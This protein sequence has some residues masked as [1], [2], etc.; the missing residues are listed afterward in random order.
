M[1]VSASRP[2]NG[3]IYADTH[4]K[5]DGK[6]LGNKSQKETDLK[7]ILF[8]LMQIKDLRDIQKSNESR[9]FYI[10]K[11]TLKKFEH[12][13]N[14]KEISKYVN[15][16]I[17]NKTLKQHN[18]W[19][20]IV[21]E[22]RKY[23]IVESNNNSEKDTH[24]IPLD[25]IY[26]KSNNI[27]YPT[28]F[29]LVEYQFLEEFN[30]FSRQNTSDII[31]EKK[32]GYIVL[33][34]SK[35]GQNEIINTT[36]I[37]LNDFTKRDDDIYLGICLEEFDF[38]VDY[39]FI[40]NQN[41]NVE[42]FLNIA[43]E[44]IEKTKNEV[45]EKNLK[46]K[47]SEGIH[48][49][50]YPENIG[51]N[52]YINNEQIYNKIL[53]YFS[54]DKMYNQFI[55]SFNNIK[56]HMLKENEID[57]NRIEQL[58]LEEKLTLDENLVYLFDESKLKNNILDDIFYYYQYNLCRP[59]NVNDK[60]ILIEN[61]FDKEDERKN[62]DDK[63][64][65]E[66]LFKF[67]SYNDICCNINRKISLISPEIYQRIQ[68]FLN[69]TNTNYTKIET[70]LIKINNEL[71]IYFNKEKNFAKLTNTVINKEKSLHE[72]NIW[73]IKL[74]C[75]DNKN[76]KEIIKEKIINVPNISQSIIK[77]IFLISQQKVEI[78]NIM[79]DHTITEMENFVLINRQW[80][81]KYK[82]H[83]KYL[84]ILNNLT[85]IKLESNNYYEFKQYLE[86][87]DTKKFDN[88]NQEIEAFPDELKNPQYILFKTEKYVLFEFPK[89]FDIINIDLFQQLIKEESENDS[90]DIRINIK[91]HNNFRIL[92]GKKIIILIEEIKNNLFIYSIESKKSFK[93]KYAFNFIN[94]NILQEEIK[95]IKNAD[96]IENYITKYGLNVK[97]TMIQEIVFNGSKIGQ[98]L[99]ISNTLSISSYEFPP[100]IG[101]ENVGATC[102]MNATLQ[103]FSNV[104]LLTDYF[105]YAKEMILNSQKSFTL[106]DEYIKLLLNLWNKDINKNKRFYA[107]QDFKKRIGEKNPLFAGIN[108][109][110]SKDLIL[111]ILEELHNDLNGINLS[112]EKNNDII[113]QSFNS[114]PIYDEH[115]NINNNIQNSEIAIYNEFIS[116]YNYKNNSIIKD[117]FYGVQES[118]TVCSNCKIQLYSF[119]IINFLIFPLEK[120]RQFLLKFNTNFSKVTLENCFQH[121]ISAEDLIGQNKMYCN[122]C[123]GEY[124]AKTYNIIYNHPKVLIIILNRGKGIEFNV[125]F[126]YPYNFDL[127]KFINMNNNPNYPNK[128]KKIEYE[129]ISVITHLGESG[130]SGHFISCAKSPVDHNWYLYNDAIVSECKDPL[131]V[132]G[133]ATSSS[134]PYVL[135]YQLKENN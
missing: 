68:L 14:I 110:D 89:Y 70:N 74:M 77:K 23:I 12:N 116:D 92:L 66:K 114:N 85:D 49:I 53:Y 112:K 51:F 134:I 18:D 123:K 41:I 4:F 60:K 122:S 100:L 113:N 54:I 121:Y 84:Y 37:I 132:F 8:L 105:F 31:P 22:M 62:D 34:P 43:K 63:V 124:D 24:N 30:N 119:T 39:L 20:K 76:D 28:N 5:G 93:P 109:N 25:I 7:T 79:I 16:F 45:V 108:A 35:N 118:V 115:D 19:N 56:N 88:I 111:F 36:Y 64:K 21:K 91:E 67:L 120:V 2:K 42:T 57:I 75:E 131:N 26:N 90:Y 73:S 46:L 83:Y 52:D 17:K 133:N 29:S 87:I 11:E 15:S 50:Y 65:L 86:S 38:K 72:H 32:L 129:L 80:F 71:Y 101:L 96:N 47:I 55:S 10:I 58:I 98:F 94:S 13:Y 9:N 135:F 103:C 27:K 127:N 69:K 48:M 3:Y 81:E 82:E 117:V 78:N 1:G 107:P 125:P 97:N 59:K 128:N 44:N 130:M 104:D 61:I 99:I 6:P 95:S 102:Y 40:V 126:T 106:V 33:I